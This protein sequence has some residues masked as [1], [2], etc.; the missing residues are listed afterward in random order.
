MPAESLA[1]MDESGLGAAQGAACTNALNS[2]VLSRTNLQHLQMSS[3]SPSTPTSDHSPISTTS[4]GILAQPLKSCCMEPAKDRVHTGTGSQEFEA[5]KSLSDC[6][7]S[8][9]RP[10]AEPRQASSKHLQ[11]STSSCTSMKESEVRQHY[12]QSNQ[13]PTYSSNRRP[14][15]AHIGV[16]CRRDRELNKYVGWNEGRSV[17]AGPQA[18][19]FN[20]ANRYS[21]L[22]GPRHYSNLMRVETYPNGFGQVL[23]LWQEDIDSLSDEEKELLAREFLAEAFVEEKGYAKYCCAIVH[24]AARGMP[25]FL[26]YLGDQHGSLTIKHGIIGHPRDMETTTMSHYRDRVRENYKS[27]TFRYGFLDNISLVG[28]VSEEA[29][30][31]FPDILDM[32]EENPFLRLTMPWGELSSLHDMN[33]TKSNDG[34]ILWIRPGEQSIPT[35]ELGKSPLKRKSTYEMFELDE[36]V[37]EE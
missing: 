28:T 29:G 1:D 17:S 31:F 4:Y 16:Q 15:R 19:G 20:A 32:L 24:G 14:K 10:L 25:D 5:M 12:L 27:G 7:N 33:P 30:G 21:T 11:A 36:S 35:G 37:M 8:S 34:P 3:S 22:H 23:H 13:K 9:Y 26:E 6:G 18:S 2:F